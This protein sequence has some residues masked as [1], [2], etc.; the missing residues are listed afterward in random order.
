MG[1]LEF[2]S[3]GNGLEK[4]FCTPVVNFDKILMYC[5]YEV[6]RLNRSLHT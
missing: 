3:W 2:L 6:T 5:T 4:V 1:T